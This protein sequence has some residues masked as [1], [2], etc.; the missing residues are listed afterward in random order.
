MV[1]VASAIVLLCGCSNKYIRLADSRHQQIRMASRTFAMKIAPELREYIQPWRARNL[2]V[3]DFINA[4]TAESTVSGQELHSLLLLDLRQELPG[5]QV[6]PFAQKLPTT[7]SIVVQGTTRY[8]PGKGADDSPSWFRIHLALTDFKDERKIGEASLL[9]NARQFDPMPSRFYRDAPMYLTGSRHKERI[10]AVAGKSQN[11]RSVILADAAVAEAQNEYEKG[12]FSAAERKFNAIRQADRSNL[13]ALS[14]YYQSMTKLKREEEAEKAFGD[15][16]FQAISENNLSVKFL[17]RVRSKE[18]WDDGILGAH[19]TMWIRQI[20]RQVL[21]SGKCLV[22]NG[23]ASNSGSAEYNDELS[24]SRAK[25][26][27][28]KMIKVEPKLEGRLSAKGKGFRE[29][30]IG[31]GSDDALDAIDRRVEFVL[32]ACN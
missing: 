27:M 21:A 6:T 31:S 2:I 22:I 16:L 4:N 13:T 3:G 29:N 15:L 1:V 32:R 9:I 12:D 17:F 8:I 14:G 19:Y 26:V 11:V 24:L 7:D 18:F 25:W 20:S 23:H 28:E 5:V 30:I 10:D